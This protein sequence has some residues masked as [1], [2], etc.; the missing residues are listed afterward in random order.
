MTSMANHVG[1]PTFVVG[2]QG[3]DREELLRV[4]RE[5]ASRRALLP[6]AAAA[7]GQA[8]MR[9]ERQSLLDGLR[10]LTAAM[11]DYGLVDTRRPGWLGALELLVKR[12]IRKLFLRH[13]VQQHRVHLKLTKLLG[14][15]I[16]YLEVYDQALRK[17]VDRCEP[18]KQSPGHGNGGLPRF[19]LSLSSSE[20][21]VHS[22]SR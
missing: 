4:V 18:G 12:S 14:R 1:E 5:N 10:E 8:R 13:I 9:E 7:L 11:R 22:A 3:I 21:L 17:S 19:E 15:V 16:S 6:H 20:E 2:A